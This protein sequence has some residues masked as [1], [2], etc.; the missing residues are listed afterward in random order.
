MAGNRKY[1]PKMYGHRTKWSLKIVLFCL[2]K[3]ISARK[4]HKNDTYNLQAYDTLFHG[5]TWF[6]NYGRGNK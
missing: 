2:C 5:D 1:V 3:S 4:K 6:D